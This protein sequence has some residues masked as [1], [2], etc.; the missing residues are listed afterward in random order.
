MRN[1][2]LLALTAI[3]IAGTLPAQ[4]PDAEQPSRPMDTARILT[5]FDGETDAAR[6]RTV[7]DGVM[8][9]RSSG[10]FAV[11]EGRMLFTGVLNTNG[12]GFSSVRRSGR[13]LKL[14]Q[15]GEQGIR[16]R[17]RGDGRTYTLRLRQPTGQRRFRAS[18]RA[19][20]ATEKGSGWQNVFVPYASLVP[21]WRGRTLDLPPVKPSQVDELGVSI[22]DKIDG[23]FRI[24]IDEIATY[25]RFDFDDFRA[26]RRPL[27]LFA[28]DAEDAALQKQL[29]AIADARSGCDER[30]MAVVVVLAHGTSRAG[31]RQLTKAEAA[32]L[33]DRFGRKGGSFSLLLVGKDGG[34]KRRAE[35]PLAMRDIFAQVDRMPMRIREA[36]RRRIE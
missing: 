15:D 1:L 27:V 16:L 31:D 36:Q 11:A 14:G 23:P 10:E 25:G 18:Y 34:V 5:D 6:W 24:E 8:G 17:V 13:D 29:T 30:D 28:K 7:L 9:G 3:C 20:F 32:E 22:D 21:T 2:P 26:D 33:R 4:T 12:G 19:R 35:Q